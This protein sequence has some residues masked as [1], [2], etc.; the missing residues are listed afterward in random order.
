M[1]Q[2]NWYARRIGLAAI[3][4]ATELYMIQDSSVGFENTW[5]FLDRRI[6][7][8]KI[9]HDMLIQS[10]GATEHLTSAVG[11]AFTTARNILGLNFNR[12]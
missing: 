3:F 11:T 9:V 7:E 1:L 12:R 8:S 10:E 6:A 5:K 4:K 2:I